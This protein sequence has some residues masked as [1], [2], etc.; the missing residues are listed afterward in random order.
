MNAVHEKR[1][2]KAVRRCGDRDL[3]PSLFR[4]RKEVFMLVVVAVHDHGM[5][6]TMVLLVV[7]LIVVTM[8][9]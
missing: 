7:L 8:Q 5:M 3:P 9:W 1:R 6:A 2:A 4:P